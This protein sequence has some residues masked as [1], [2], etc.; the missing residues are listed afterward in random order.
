MCELAHTN[1]KSRRR[2]WPWSFSV[3]LVGATGVVP[4]QSTVRETGW[5]LAVGGTVYFGLIGPNV[6][7]YSE[8]RPRSGLRPF[9]VFVAA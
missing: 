2:R 3:V 5:Q 7:M 6:L 8:I 4:L 9:C 1:S